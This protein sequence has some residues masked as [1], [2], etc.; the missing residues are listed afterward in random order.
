M[1]RLLLSVVAGVAT[2]YLVACLALFLLQRS[3]IY[4]PQPR[5]LASPD[6]TELLQV[7]NANL[8]ITVRAA[9][10]NKALIYFGGNAEDVSG[11]LPSLSKAFADHA[12]YLA[13]YR[14]FGGSSGK[15]TEAALHADA[16]AL[17]DRVHRQHTNVL[18]IGRSLGSGVAVRLA[19]VRPAS[20]L[21]LVTPY[22][23]IENIAAAQFPMFPV[24]WLLQDKFESWRYAASISAPTSIVTAQYDE[25]IPADSSR[26]LHAQ[27]RKDLARFIVVPNATHNTIS[28]Q[29]A[30][31]LAL[32]ESALMW[33]PMPERAPSRR[34]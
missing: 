18:V 28:D 20:R 16:V 17:F 6:S 3:L 21:V 33:G 4:F 27:F 8:I 23:S 34:E 29:P 25:V 10:G 12:I 30:Y 22:D 31:W 9:S 14:G 26:R 13:H 11:N 1:T 7:A 19:S 24:R 15:P 32:R 2:L 5:S